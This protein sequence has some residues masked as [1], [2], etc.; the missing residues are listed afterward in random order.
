MEHALGWI[1]RRKTRRE[2]NQKITG[3]GPQDFMRYALR[4]PST[5]DA[6]SSRRPSEPRHHL[7]PPPSHPPSAI[8]HAIQPS[9]THAPGSPRSHRLCTALLCTRSSSNP[10]AAPN[11]SRLALHSRRRHL[12]RHAVVA[13]G[14]HPYPL[15]S[16]PRYA[17]TLTVV[18]DRCPVLASLALAVTN[19]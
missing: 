3:V 10:L 4:P 9:T 15:L 6:W 19:D 8:I 2:Q 14:S 12:A 11:P 16:P 5:H 1:G 18:G 7:P 17:T 13:T